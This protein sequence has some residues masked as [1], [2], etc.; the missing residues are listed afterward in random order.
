MDDHCTRAVARVA[1]SLKG[2]T[3]PVYN[4]KDLQIL[5]E[6]PTR[7]IAPPIAE[8]IREMVVADESDEAITQVA[9]TIKERSNALFAKMIQLMA[10]V[11]PTNIKRLVVG[12]ARSLATPTDKRY[13]R[14]SN[15]ADWN[16][17]TIAA[18][19]VFGTAK[20]CGS[21]TSCPVESLWWLLATSSGANGK[22]NW[23]GL[24]IR[25]AIMKSVG[26]WEKAE[27]VLQKYPDFRKEVASQLA[28]KETAA[29]IGQ[30]AVAT[31]RAEMNIVPRA[32]ATHSRGLKR[33]K[34][35]QLVNADNV[36]SAAPAA[37]AAR[38]EE[39]QVRR[40]RGRPRKYPIAPTAPI[41]ATTPNKTVPEEA[42]NENPDDKNLLNTWLSEMLS[43]G[44]AEDKFFSDLYDE[45]TPYSDDDDDFRSDIPTDLSYEMSFQAK[46]PPPPP[47][48]PLPL[49]VPTGIVPVGLD[50]A[51]TPPGR[52]NASRLTYVDEYFRSAKKAC[53]P[54]GEKFT[55]SVSAVPIAHASLKRKANGS[56]VPECEPK[57]LAAK[58]FQPMEHPDRR[59]LPFSFSHPNSNV[60]P[61]L[62][63][64]YLLNA[65]TI[66]VFMYCHEKCNDL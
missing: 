20:Y 61:A 26:C 28:F 14:T 44:E 47:P 48:T 54:F 2:E 37:L 24:L 15:A 51:Y 3:T 62:L 30:E 59:A 35:C 36:A 21:P 46:H 19:F 52:K 29:Q 9:A 18:Q 13:V 10:N 43:D 55:K 33:Q 11:D 45:I 6:K 27:G 38:A 41:A 5:A 4:A 23:Y 66:G 63:P 17:A 53:V 1:S 65:T 7:Y 49:A 22:S 57:K 31:A 50:E 16:C 34:A 40:K 56:L 12:V 25:V 32:T 64:K 60:Q 42:P 58:T 39:A 8:A